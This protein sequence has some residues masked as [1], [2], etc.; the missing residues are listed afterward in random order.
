MSNSTA[1]AVRLNALGVREDQCA[2]DTCVAMCHHRP[3]WP[4]PEE[5]EKIIEAGYGHRLMLEYWELDVDEGKGREGKIFLLSPG[6]RGAGGRH[7]PWY[8]RGT[9]LFLRQDRC[10]LHEL[11]LKPIEGRSVSCKTPDETKE[12]NVH[13]AIPP[14]WD[15]EKGRSIVEEWKEAYLKDDDD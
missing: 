6:I 13:T 1:L 5:A 7:A 11:G 4:L 2:C 9:C 12:M 3:C 8:P 14:L 15:T 10:E